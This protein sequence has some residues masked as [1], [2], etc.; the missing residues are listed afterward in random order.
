MERRAKKYGIKV[1]WEDGVETWMTVFSEYT[2]DLGGLQPASYG[3][4]SE[5]T[6]AANNMRLKN[7]K[8]MELVD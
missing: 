5:A 1:T 3:S 6:D 4:F 7:F 8:I 2:N